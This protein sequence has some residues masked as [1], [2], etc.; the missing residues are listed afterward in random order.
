MPFMRLQLQTMGFI[1]LFRPWLRINLVTGMI[2]E[3][4]TGELF[5]TKNRDGFSVQSLFERHLA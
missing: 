4:Q 1:I 2:M 5:C 3:K